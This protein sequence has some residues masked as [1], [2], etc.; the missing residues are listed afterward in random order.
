MSLLGKLFSKPPEIE[1]RTFNPED[2]SVLFSCPASLGAGLLDAQARIADHHVRCT[3]DVESIQAG[4]YF[5]IFLKP[6]QALAYL[7]SL[8][9]APQPPTDK[10]GA[11]RIERAL[12]VSSPRLPRYLALSVDLSSSGVKLRAEGPM[13]PGDEFEAQ[14]EFDDT[15][16][17]HITVLLKVAWCRS[18]AD[19][20]LV[21][22][23]FLRMPKATAA[24]L[25]YFLDDLSTI[26]KGVISNQFLFD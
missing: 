7:P 5:G 8:L 3:V 10:R 19:K 22:A 24:R 9:P 4:L 17:A 21:G 6:Q 26:E 1:L 2:N 11:K 12:R 14:I 23:S 13:P 15:V 20:Y 16:A 25:A 18:D